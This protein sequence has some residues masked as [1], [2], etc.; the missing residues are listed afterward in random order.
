MEEGIALSQEMSLLFNL[1]AEEA[2]EQNEAFL[3][4]PLDE[5]K[6]IKEEYIKKV[7]EVQAMEQSKMLPDLDKIPVINC[8]LLITTALDDDQDWGTIDEKWGP[9]PQPNGW[10]DKN[11]IK[12]NYPVLLPLPSSKM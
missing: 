1:Q 2:S 12:D 10:E 11:Y 7:A 4:S 3:L 5:A 6:K 9:L 8:M